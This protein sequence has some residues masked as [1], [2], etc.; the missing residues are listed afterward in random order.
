MGG[1]S[2]AEEEGFLRLL[3]K[4]YEHAVAA[5]AELEGRDHRASMRAKPADA[6]EPAVK[7][8]KPVRRKAG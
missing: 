7:T 1:L 6:Q 5:H 3:R 8:K 4:A 2:A